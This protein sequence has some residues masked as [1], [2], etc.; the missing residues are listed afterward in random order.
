MLGKVTI[1]FTWDTPE[2]KQAAKQFMGW[3]SN[4]GEQDYW[5]GMEYYT[6]EMN[7]TEDPKRVIQRFEYD[8][9]KLIIV[10][11]VDEEEES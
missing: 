4:S 6:P 9:D 2:A 11:E 3:L 7:N 1:T 10:G 8:D 5:N